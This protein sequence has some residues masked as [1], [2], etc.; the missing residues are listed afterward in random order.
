MNPAIDI[1]PYDAFIDQQAA[2]I[3]ARQ[4]G[5]RTGNRMQYAE[6]KAYRKPDFDDAF[7]LPNGKMAGI[8]STDGVDKFND[9]MFDV[10]ATTFVLRGL[11]KQNIPTPRKGLFPVGNAGRFK[12]GDWV[13]VD[14]EDKKSAIRRVRA[15]DGR[16]L[17]LDSP[18]NFHPVL[19]GDVMRIIGKTSS[20]VDAR[21]TERWNRLNR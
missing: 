6:N 3:K 20:G 18:L 13:L 14:T 1:N 9:Y 19:G 5:Y 17:I 21:A 16:V 8:H 11:P 15:I 4:D 7:Q 12:R 10:A 2:E